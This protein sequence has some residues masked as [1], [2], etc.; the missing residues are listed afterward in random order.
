[1]LPDSWLLTEPHVAQ[2]TII[3]KWLKCG[4][5]CVACPNP[6][7]TC[8]VLAEAAL[9][10][11]SAA[12]RSKPKPTRTRTA[13]FLCFGS[14]PL[15]LLPSVRRALSCGHR[16][17]ESSPKFQAGES[18]SGSGVVFLTTQCVPM[19]YENCA[20]AVCECLYY[21]TCFDYFSSWFCFLFCQKNFVSFFARGF[22]SG[23]KAVIIQQ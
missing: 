9:D 13:H 3:P 12:G 20:P 22:F 7:R 17:G 21:S 5:A 16:G 23:T 4:K 8:R 15:Q 19:F 14:C 1:M 10:G 18:H 2:V 11:L 6:L